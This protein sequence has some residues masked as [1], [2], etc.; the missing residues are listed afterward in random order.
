MSKSREPTRLLNRLCIIDFHI[1][2]WMYIYTNFHTDHLRTWIHIKIFVMMV[3]G[4]TS[5]LNS[6][7][8]RMRSLRGFAR[9]KKLHSL[10]D[11]WIIKKRARV[12]WN[13][14]CRCTYIYVYVCTLCNLDLPF[15]FQHIFVQIYIFFFKKINIY[16]IYIYQFFTNI[17]Y[18]WNLLHFQWRF[19][20]HGEFYFDCTTH[21]NHGNP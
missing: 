2:V 13:K 3:R 19:F 11:E 17:K 18:R 16:C 5:S 14:I 6:H 21:K 15:N 10:R 4:I 1:Y 8:S 7:E 12:I 20:A 9:Y